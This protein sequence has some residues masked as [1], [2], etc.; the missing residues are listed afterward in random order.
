M[1]FIKKLLKRTQMMISNR[2]FIEKEEVHIVTLYICT[3]KENTH[4]SSE[5]KKAKPN[6]TVDVT[7]NASPAVNSSSTVISS[8]SSVINSG[9]S[10]IKSSTS[11]VG[12]SSSINNSSLTVANR[13]S[14]VVESS[15]RVITIKSTIKNIWNQNYLRPLYDLVDNVNTLVSHTFGFSKYIFLEELKRTIDFN[16]ADFVNKEFFVKVFLALVSRRNIAGRLN[17]RTAIYREL[18]S[19][20]K[21]SY[22]QDAQYTPFELKYAQQLALYECTKINTAYQNNIK[23]QFGNRLRVLLNKLSKREEKLHSLHQ[24]MKAKDST[25]QAMKEARRKEV[26]EPIARM[27][28]SVSKKFQRKIMSG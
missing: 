1:K 7:S 26:F 28:L 2:L 11:A 19:F 3:D 23:A 6:N 12:S 14:S 22:F 18:I 4:Y 21:A 15:K 13:S 16:L 5:N 10:V 9:S 24:S 27:K 17:N 8:N 20:H 25:E